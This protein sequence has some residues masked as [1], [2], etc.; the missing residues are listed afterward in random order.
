MRAWHKGKTMRELRMPRGGMV[1]ML[2][3]N[4]MS[5]NKGKNVI[6]LIPQHW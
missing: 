5:G 3:I 6:A 1:V 2:V 4:Y